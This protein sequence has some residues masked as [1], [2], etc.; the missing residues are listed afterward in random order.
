M[1]YHWSADVICT[2]IKTNRAICPKLCG[3]CLFP[4]NFHTRKLGEIKVFYALRT[5]KDIPNYGLSLTLIRVIWIRE[6]PYSGIFY[7]VLFSFKISYPEMLLIQLKP[8]EKRRVKEVTL[9]VLNSLP[10]SFR[11]TNSNSFAI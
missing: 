8:I 6:N 9:T 4:Q 5:A 7:V 1:S 2:S 3:S 10:F 11:S